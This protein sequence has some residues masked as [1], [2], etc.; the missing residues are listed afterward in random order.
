MKSFSPLKVIP[1]YYSPFSNEIFSLACIPQSSVSSSPIFVSIFLLSRS[2]FLSRFYENSLLLKEPFEQEHKNG[3]WGQSSADTVLT[4]DDEDLNA[5]EVEAKR[6]ARVLFTVK[7]RNEQKLVCSVYAHME[8]LVSFAN[9]SC[10]IFWA[11]VGEDVT[12]PGTDR[13]KLGGLSQCR[14]ASVT[15]TAVLQATGAEVGIAALSYALKSLASTFSQ[16]V[17]SGLP[18]WDCLSVK[19]VVV[20]IPKDRYYQEAERKALC[21]KG[22]MK[23]PK[24]EAMSSLSRAGCEYLMQISLAP[25]NHIPLRLYRDFLKESPA[26]HDSALCCVGMLRKQLRKLIILSTGT[27]EGFFSVTVGK[28]LSNFVGT[29]MDFDEK[30]LMPFYRDFMR[31]R[32]KLDV[33]KPIRKYSAPDRLQ[34]GHQ[35]TRLA[36]YLSSEEF[37]RSSISYSSNSDHLQMAERLESSEYSAAAAIGTFFRADQIDRTNG[38]HKRNSLRRK[39]V[40][41]SSKLFYSIDYISIYQC[42]AL[43]FSHTVLLAAPYA[44]MRPSDVL[45]VERPF[46]VHLGPEARDPVLFMRKSRTVAVQVHPAP[47]DA[48]GTRT[49]L[50]DSKESLMNIME[51]HVQVQYLLLDC[52]PK[53]AVLDERLKSSEY[54]AAATIGTFFRFA[55]S[56]SLVMRWNLSV[57]LRYTRFT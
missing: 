12:L 19:M 38:G 31:V 14:L 30:N 3:F 17:L 37:Q 4:C 39:F 28:A 42:S 33:R 1:D 9:M 55:K 56:I 16:L 52:C 32:V 23:F 8:E 44:G 54:F 35:D 24:K 26:D 53:R 36:D 13:G 48:N 41:R 11:N 25:H 46:K 45:E 57:H 51:D 50:C 2:G 34:L 18:K 6:W 47:S 22:Y 15:T 10:P 7:V 29:Y 40:K 20:Y 49:L 5:W 27:N 43:D 21:T